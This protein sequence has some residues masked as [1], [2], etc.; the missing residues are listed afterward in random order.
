MSTSIA[1]AF[2]P[3]ADPAS[4]APWYASHLG[5]E[6]EEVT[7]WSAVLSGL[8]GA[9]LTLM[10]PSSGIAA[11]PGLDWASCNFRVADLGLQHARL[12]SGGLEVSAVEG[13]PEVCLFFTARDPD[14]NILLVTD[15]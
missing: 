9:R 8:E 6:V 13:D 1:G 7:A 10:G 2:I 15:R 3:V 12:A 5:L 11:Q 4:A 14:G